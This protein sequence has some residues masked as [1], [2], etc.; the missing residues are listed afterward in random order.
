MRLTPPALFAILLLTTPGLA[1][2]NS[3][4][5]TPAISTSTSASAPNATSTASGSDAIAANSKNKKTAQAPEAKVS[6][7]KG[8]QTGMIGASADVASFRKAVDE[9]AKDPHKSADLFLQALAA[10]TMKRDLGLQ[11]IAMLLPRGDVMEDDGIEIP[12]RFRQDE[13]LQLD[14]K[15]YTIQ[16]YCGGT[17][18][19]GYKN[20]DVPNC[21]AVFDTDYSKTRQG[22]GYPAEGKAKFFI[23][24]GGSSRP[25]PIE[26]ERNSDGNWFVDKFGLL[27]G[28]AA[29]AE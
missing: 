10:Y 5:A 4:Q 22:V 27:S 18:E 8:P 15:P 9:S 3:T 26:M 14:K 19:K 13:L 24:N 6:T 25:R 29:P 12:N 1:C 11:M 17:P 21:A 28:V 16:G 23:S 2:A 7:K 20:A